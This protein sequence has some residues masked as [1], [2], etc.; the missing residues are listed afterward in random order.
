MTS[1]LFLSMVE[2]WYEVYAPVAQVGVIGM[3]VAAFL[4]GTIIF[5]ALLL[6]NYLSA[7]VRMPS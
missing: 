4:L 1:G 6:R 7:S 2:A 5:V 3:V